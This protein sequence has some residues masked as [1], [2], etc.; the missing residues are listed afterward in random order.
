VP[1]TAISAAGTAAV[2]CS[3]L[4][5]EVASGEPFHCTVIPF[6]KFA[7][8]TVRTKADEVAV[9]NGGARLV[10]T[11]A[12]VI[13]KV[14]GAELTPSVVITVTAAVPGALTSAAGTA[15]VSCDALT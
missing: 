4:T 6:A 12:E 15:A 8:F 9:R 7:P 14:N 5:K 10:I 13:R 3:A 2:S 1:G 11:G